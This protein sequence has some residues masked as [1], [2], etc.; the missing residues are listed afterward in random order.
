MRL[1]K[2]RVDLESFDCRVFRQRKNIL[3]RA[4]ALTAEKAVTI[5]Q[6]RVSQR[7]VWIFIDRL[8]EKINCL[9]IA[10]L[11]TFVPVEAALQVKPIRFRIV[12]VMLGEAALLVA[13]N[14]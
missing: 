3:R 11:R 8:P 12:G 6:P 14:C 10:L 2:S 4:N 13:R 1:R 7:I 5:S 9:L